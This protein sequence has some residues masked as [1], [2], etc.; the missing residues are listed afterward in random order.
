M[1]LGAARQCA[2]AKEVSDLE[3]ED[4]E[5]RGPIT[6]RDVEHVASVLMDSPWALGHDEEAGAVFVRLVEASIAPT[7]ERRQGLQTPDP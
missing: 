5:V 4:R 3:E 1:G 6:W 7:D 2:G